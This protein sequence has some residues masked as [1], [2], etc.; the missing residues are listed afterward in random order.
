MN[1]TVL[2]MKIYGPVEVRQFMCEMK[3]RTAFYANIFM[4]SNVVV[5]ASL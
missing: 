1:L 5:A 4:Q 3:C 2:A